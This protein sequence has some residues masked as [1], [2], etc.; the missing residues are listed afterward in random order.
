M[1]IKPAN[2]MNLDYTAE[3][4]RMT[5]RSPMIDVHTHIQGPRAAEM[6]AQVA[7]LFGI[8]MTYSMTP[9]DQINAVAERLAGRI[10]FI[11]MPNFG[12]DNLQS[13]VTDE[14]C[15]QI[16]SL[17]QRGERIVKIW[18][19]PRGRDL[20]RDRGFPDAFRI[21]APH[22]LVAMQLAAKLG[23]AIMVHIGDPDTWFAA[24]YTDH[25]HYG[26]K[27]EH[28]H[29]LADTLDRLETNVIAAHMGGWP[30]NLD[31]LSEMLDKHDN[32]HLDTSA[33]KWM[34]R[35]LSQHPRSRLVDFLTRWTGRILFGSDIVASDK[36]FDP[37]GGVSAESDSHARER[38]VFDQYA[39]RYFALRTLFE[40]DYSGESPIADPDLAMVDPNTYDETDAPILNGKS[41]PDSILKNLYF[42]AAN[43][44]LQ[45]LYAT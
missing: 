27:R 41:L 22:N 28:Y 1:S 35:E 42:D 11:A 44:L 13:S 17:H 30:E 19:A 16:K 10:R 8:T 40:T 20:G 26:T 38:D 6:Y 32:L 15:E 39:S 23:M 18:A 9:H 5:N 7:D 37:D 14:F 2:R 21:E 33:T 36:H 29:A 3:A 34:V 31:F 43:E 45:P 4:S 25:G 12:S 24:K